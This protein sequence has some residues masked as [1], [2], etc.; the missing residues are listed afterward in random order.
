MVVGLP[1][2]AVVFANHIFLPKL[3]VGGEYQ[4]I[5]LETEKSGLKVDERADVETLSIFS[6]GSGWDWLSSL[7]PAP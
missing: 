4:H 5:A 6:P 3:T 1:A 7:Q 2:H